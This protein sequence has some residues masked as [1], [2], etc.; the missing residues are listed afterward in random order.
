MIRPRDTDDLD[1]NSVDNI[2]HVRDL[3]ATFLH[4]LGIDQIRFNFKQQGLAMRLT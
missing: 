3:H 1:Y 2:V 4:L